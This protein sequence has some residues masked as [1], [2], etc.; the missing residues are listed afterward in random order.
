MYKSVT[1][2]KIH[3]LQSYGCTFPIGDLSRWV[4]G[5]IFKLQ[6]Y[7]LFGIN[8]T[9]QSTVLL[10]N[11]SNNSIGSRNECVIVYMCGLFSLEHLSKVNP[12]LSTILLL[13]F[14]FL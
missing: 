13:P 3:N 14:P 6:Q 5:N 7:L 4:Q 10:F 8:L 9:Q 12:S 2:T 1:V 11:F